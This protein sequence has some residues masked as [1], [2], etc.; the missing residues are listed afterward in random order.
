MDIKIQKFQGAGVK[1]IRRYSKISVA[2]KKVAK[3][4]ELLV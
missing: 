3:F 4:C 1:D 2:S